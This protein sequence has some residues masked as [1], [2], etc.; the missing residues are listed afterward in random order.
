VQHLP[1]IAA[2]VVAVIILCIAIKQRYKTIIIGWKSP[3]NMRTDSSTP[4]DEESSI[5]D[6]HRQRATDQSIAT[7]TQALSSI[8]RMPW[9]VKI[10]HTQDEFCDFLGKDNL[11]MVVRGANLMAMLLSRMS[12][13]P[14]SAGRANGNYYVGFG[15]AKIPCTSEAMYK[16]LTVELNDRYFSTVLPRRKQIIQ[17]LANYTERADFKEESWRFAVTVDGGQGLM[18][19]TVEAARDTANTLN[20]QYKKIIDPVRSEI[21]D[22]ILRL[23]NYELDVILSLEK[24]M[25][26]S[27]NGGK[28][29]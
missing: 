14:A 27:S 3:M 19:E 28:N 17:S 2:T 7:Q 29:S 16:A 11:G 24:Q 5:N 9:Q 21:V 10:L 23:A 1:S 18:C 13:P 26:K 20:A 4:G 12:V 25:L 8:D 22:R 15:V 6:Y